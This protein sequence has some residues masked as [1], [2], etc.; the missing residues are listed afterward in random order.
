MATGRP[1]RAKLLL[2]GIE[3]PFIGATITHTVNQAAIA[4]VDLVPHKI[5]NNIKPRT[6]VQLYVRDYQDTVTGGGFPYVTAFEGEVFGYS[7]AKTPSSRT[8][9]I[10][11]IDFTSYWDNVLTYFFNAQQSLGKGANS[12]SKV[13]FERL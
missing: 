11:C 1:L 4:Y 10:S 13:G 5:I 12:L 9:S 2:E 8:F 6:L 3:V 7:F